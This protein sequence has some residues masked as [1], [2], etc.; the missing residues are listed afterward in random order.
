MT[1][2]RLFVDLWKAGVVLTIE[3]NRLH[4]EADADLPAHLIQTLRDHKADLMH[5]LTHWL[6]IPGYGQCKLW[7]FLSDGRAGVVLRKQPDRVTWIS[8]R[9]IGQ[10][11]IPTENRK[12]KSKIK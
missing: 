11:S 1:P 2:G 3:D 7:G 12:T 4:F 6:E 9:A 8:K 10:A 5:L